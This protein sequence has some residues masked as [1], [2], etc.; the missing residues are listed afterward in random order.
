MKALTPLIAFSS[1]SLS[2]QDEQDLGAYLN[3]TCYHF[4]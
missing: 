4:K 3:K 1:H 2:K